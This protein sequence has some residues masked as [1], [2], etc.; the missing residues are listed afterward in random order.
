MKIKIFE[1]INVDNLE[2]DI[3]KWLSSNEKKITIITIKQSYSGE[4]IDYNQQIVM[5]ILYK[6]KEKK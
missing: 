4:S 1:N 5:S 3:N 6:I 2:E